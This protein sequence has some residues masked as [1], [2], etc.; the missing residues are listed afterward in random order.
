RGFHPLKSIHAELPLDHIAVDLAGPFP[1]SADGSNYLLVM[2]DVATRFVFLR[3]LTDKR[4][5]TVARVLLHIFADVGFPKIIQSDNGS[6][7]VN[8]LITNVTKAVGIDH[9]LVTPYH[10][11]ANGLVERNVQTAIAAI[12]KQLR[13]A[14]QEWTRYV[15]GVQLAMNSKVAAIHGSTPF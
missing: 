9:R 14:K 6:E 12:R 8:A 5:E 11:Q 15:A 1:T 10:P 13:G 3:P 4:A 2:V 7:F